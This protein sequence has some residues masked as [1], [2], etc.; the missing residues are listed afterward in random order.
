LIFLSSL[1]KI[2]LSVSLQFLTL[3]KIQG[4]GFNKATLTN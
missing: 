2:Y 3:R 4:P 1:R